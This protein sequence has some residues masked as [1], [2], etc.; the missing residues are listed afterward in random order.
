MA[1]SRLRIPTR[2]WPGTVRPRAEPIVPMI[3]V[4]FLL[5]VFFLLAARFAD[6]AE[7]P[8]STVTRSDTAPLPRVLVLAASGALSYGTLTGEAAL[9]AAVADGPVRLQVAG[10]VEAVRLAQALG[11]LATAGASRVDV[12]TTAG[13]AR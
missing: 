13:P 11:Q 5:L 12:I 10:S 1:R 4:V 8:G 3:N 6:T 7:G 2:D 9:A